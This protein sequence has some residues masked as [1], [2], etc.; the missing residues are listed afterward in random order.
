MYIF[1][2][3][4]TIL[5]GLGGAGALL[6]RGYEHDSELYTDEPVEEGDVGGG[7]R[8]FAL[9]VADR[10]LQLL[11]KDDRYAFPQ[12][13]WHRPCSTKDE[14]SGFGGRNRNLEV[15]DGH[16]LL[17]DGDRACGWG[18]GRSGSAV[19]IEG[20]RTQTAVLHLALDR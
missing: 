3:P 16:D 6:F 17:G 18:T 5:F 12:V 19:P 2:F 15:D 14:L 10:R 8:L 1:D 4:A 7:K 9:L 13:V 11:H 20:W